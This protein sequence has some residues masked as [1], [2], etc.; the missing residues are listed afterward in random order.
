MLNTPYNLIEGIKTKK[1][2]SILEHALPDLDPVD[3]SSVPYPILYLMRISVHSFVNAFLLHALP[4]S[5]VILNCYFEAT[6]RRDDP[7]NPYEYKKL[8]SSYS[9]ISYL[10][11]KIRLEWKANHFPSPP[12]FLPPPPLQR[13]LQELDEQDRKL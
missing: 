13:N 8:P 6:Q 2:I 1:I 5:F 3:H 12:P 11:G 7:F 10:A 4:H 9:Q